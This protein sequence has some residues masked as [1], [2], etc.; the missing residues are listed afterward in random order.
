MLLEDCEGS[1]RPIKKLEEPHFPVLPDFKGASYEKRY[2]LL[3]N[4]LVLEKLFDG[5]ALLLTRRPP[6]ITPYR[7]PETLGLRRF[8]AGLAGH[9]QTCLSV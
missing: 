5:A 4:K 6:E 9:V 2:E 8:L 3:L 1:T 7:E